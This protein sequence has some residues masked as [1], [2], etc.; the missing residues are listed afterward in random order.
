VPLLGPVDGAALAAMAAWIAAIPL[1]D[2]PQQ[3]R[4]ADGQIRPAMVTDLA[5][6]GFAAMAE[7]ITREFTAGRLTWHALSCIMPG[8]SI[9]AHR[10]EQPIDWLYRAHVPL[11]TNPRAT[12]N[13]EHFAAGFAYAVDTTE[14]HEVRND[15]ASPRI[16]FMFD[17]GAR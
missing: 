8:H 15:G 6:R 12:F 11:L 5:W 16:H 13:G 9:P 17:V 4:L 7:P 2:W 10:D 1:E 14:P 3:H